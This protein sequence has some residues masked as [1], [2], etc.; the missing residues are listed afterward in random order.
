MAKVRLKLADEQRVALALRTFV[1]AFLALMCL[2]LF[3]VLDTVRLPDG[4]ELGSA[5]GFAFLGA[6]V[7]ALLEQTPLWRSRL[8]SRRKPN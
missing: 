1:S 4:G 6:S 5:A 7:L 3:V 8:P 2:I